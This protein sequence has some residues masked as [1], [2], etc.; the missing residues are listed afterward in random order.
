[1]ALNL[2]TDV[3]TTF[4]HHYSLKNNCGDIDYRARAMVLVIHMF[5]QKVS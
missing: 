4:V 5:L 3:I 1:M 2:K